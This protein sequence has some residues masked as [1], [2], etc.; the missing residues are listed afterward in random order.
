M[1]SEL[2]IMG[3]AI[4]VRICHHFETRFNEKNGCMETKVWIHETTSRPCALPEN[5]IPSNVV[6]KT[7]AS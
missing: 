2:H 6:G 1:T 3:G 5:E 4:V 7:S